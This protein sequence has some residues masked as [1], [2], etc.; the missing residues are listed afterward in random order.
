V[1]QTRRNNINANNQTKRTKNNIS[2]PLQAKMESEI[3]EDLARMIV[4][5]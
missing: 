4:P 2:F 3:P 5:L 1:K